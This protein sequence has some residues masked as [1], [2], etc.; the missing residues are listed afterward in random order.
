MVGLRFMTNHQASV[1]S[2][3]ESAVASVV[4]I[5][6]SRIVIEFITQLVT[7]YRWSPQTGVGRMTL[8]S[9]FS[10]MSGTAMTL[11]N[12]GNV[13]LMQLQDLYS[14][15]QQL[16]TALPK[17]AEAAASVKLKKAFQS[18]L[19]ETQNQATRLE[20]AFKLLGQEIKSENCDAMKGL[21]A[22]GSEIIN[23][24]GEPDVKDAAMIAAAQ[25]VEHYEI[26]GYGCARAFARRLG[27]NEVA[28]LLQ[29][30]IEE[31][32]NADKLLTKITESYDFR[33]TKMAA[34]STTATAKSAGR[35][36]SATKRPAPARTATARGAAAK[37]TTTTRAKKRA[38]KTKA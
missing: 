17:M 18:H 3:S 16:I 10:K 15:E 19:K 21:I 24:E 23:M 6:R 35:T 22:E 34:A 14:A 28:K 11:D 9:W 7:C 29:A 37:R 20:K 4:R 33:K 12:L 5:L 27:H 8:A 1:Q 25:R 30:T 2:A 36:R 38:T 13:L 31:E 26:A 32:G